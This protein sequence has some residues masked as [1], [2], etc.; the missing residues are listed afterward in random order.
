MENKYAT[1]SGGVNY[2]EFSDE[3]ESV[4]TAKGLVKNPTYEVKEFV[5]DDPTLNILSAK[6]QKVYQ[7]IID[8]MVELVRVHVIDPLTYLEDYDFFSEG[9]VSTH[10]FRSVLDDVGLPVDDEEIV[11]LAHRF[12]TTKGMDRVNYRAFSDALMEAAYE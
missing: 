6:D 8:R 2:V 9:T 4:F 12:A 3:L 7:K 1:S 10:Q 5:T 11:V